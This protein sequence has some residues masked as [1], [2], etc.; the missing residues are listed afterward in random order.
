MT[1]ATP[2]TTAAVRAR[3]ACG[4][5]QVCDGCAGSFPHHAHHKDTLS[6]VDHM[7]PAEAR[8]WAFDQSVA[9]CF[10]D[11]LARSVPDYLRMRGLVFAV[12]SRYVRPQTTI[13]DLGAS[14][15]EAHWP[16]LRR[17]GSLNHHV[18][19][20]V[21]DPMLAALRERYDGWTETTRAVPRPLVDVRKLD[22]RTEYPQVSASLTLAVLTLQFTPIECR[23]QIVRRAY[24]ATV[25]GGA[26]VV[27]EKVLG[28]GAELDDALVHLY[29]AHKEA[30]GYSREAIERKRLALQGALVP[31]T[32]AANEALLR[33]AGFAHVDCFWRS[34]N[35][36]AWV[37]VRE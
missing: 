1:P 32:A 28:A 19:C 25:P 34:L 8:A 10:D 14:R 23:Q 15:G 12:G 37:A 16:F 33:G 6:S 17:F 22:L 5:N 2:A 7:P 21:S 11:M 36:A 26:L 24:K 13:V 9:D 31:L 35:F 30:Q 18:L 27:V 4:P 20:E 3:C 29:L